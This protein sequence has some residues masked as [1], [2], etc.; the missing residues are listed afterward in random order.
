[1]NKVTA[2]HIRYG[3]F[4]TVASVKKLQKESSVLSG[5]YDVKVSNVTKGVIGDKE[6]NC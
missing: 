3:T 4:E 1:M 5:A 2:E 6:T